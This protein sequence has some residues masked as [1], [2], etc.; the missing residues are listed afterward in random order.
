MEALAETALQCDVTGLGGEVLELSA[1]WTE[2]APQR[3][4]QQREEIT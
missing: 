4:K 1:F 3:Q 2:R